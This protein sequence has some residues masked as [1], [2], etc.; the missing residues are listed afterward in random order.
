MLLVFLGGFIAAVLAYMALQHPTVLTRFQDSFSGNL[1]GREIIVP[2]SLDMIFDRPLLGWQPVAYWQELGQRV[3][4]IW[5][6]RDA[7]NLLFHLLLEVGLVGTV[8]F[9][10]G[11]WL[12]V[13]G[14]WRGRGGK[15]GNLPF[16]LLV[17]TLSANL[18]H[19]YIA[20]K[21]QWLILGLAVAA[22]ASV[23]RR[24]AAARYLVRRPL[25]PARAPRPLLVSSG[26]PRAF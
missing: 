23:T 9:L 5:G 12:C 1:A 17:M 11:L 25:H 10:I 13:V 21:P 16:A 26:R 24:S 15:L 22:A 6:A 14:A 18:S 4:R 7:H 20:R 19:T 3:G 8:P 2:A